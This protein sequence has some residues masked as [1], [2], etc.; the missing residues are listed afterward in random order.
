MPL[1]QIEEIQAGFSQCQA[2]TLADIASKTVLYVS[3]AKK[4][5][6]ERLDALCE[7][8]AEMLSGNAAQDLVAASGG[9]SD[10]L[11]QESIVIQGDET[12][13]FLRSPVDPAE[14]LLC[15]CEAG[16]DIREFLAFGRS[17]LEEMANAH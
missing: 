3:A 14:A 13:I 11:M 6:Q 8:A 17:K 1:A 16:L 12:L 5:P 9:D 10:D 4:Q 2:V 15:V 7:A